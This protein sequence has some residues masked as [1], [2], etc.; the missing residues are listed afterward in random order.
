MS[1]LSSSN[2]HICL[3]SNSFSGAHNQ[4]HDIEGADDYSLT[5]TRRFGPNIAAAVNEILIYRGVRDLIKPC[6]V[7][8]TLYRPSNYKRSS[9]EL[10]IYPVYHREAS[11]S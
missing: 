9:G 11:R 2:A 6:D 8:S 4:W 1:R 3:G 5:Q 7:P 10:T